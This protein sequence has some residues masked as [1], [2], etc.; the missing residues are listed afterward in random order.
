M[1][2]VCDLFV[3][4]AVVVVGRSSISAKARRLAGRESTCPPQNSIE[5]HR[6]LLRG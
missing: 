2:A 6:E 3:A 4:V 5:L 1:R